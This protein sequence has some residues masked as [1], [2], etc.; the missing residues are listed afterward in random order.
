MI[1]YKQSDIFIM[2]CIVIFLGFYSASMTLRG[3]DFRKDSFFG[4]SMG[5]IPFKYNNSR[6]FAITQSIVIKNSDI[7]HSVYLFKFYGFFYKKELIFKFIEND[8][9]VSYSSQQ[10]NSWLNWNGNYQL[11]IKIK[12]VKKIYV[13]KDKIHNIKINYL[14]L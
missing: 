3:L 8:S 7:V 1:K 6:D 10:A 5:D 13:K 14:Y 4:E 11:D 2:L 9:S 12:S